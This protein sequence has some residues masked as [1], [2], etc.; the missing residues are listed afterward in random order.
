MK[1]YNFYKTI[2]HYNNNDVAHST[3]FSTFDE[4]F[5]YCEKLGNDWVFIEADQVS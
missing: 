3:E 5:D 1:L 4:A 2:D